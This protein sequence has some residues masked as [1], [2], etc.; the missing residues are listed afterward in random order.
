MQGY[1]S[2]PSELPS[3]INETAIDNRTDRGAQKP[4]A[5]LDSAAASIAR[6]VV[7]QST[8]KIG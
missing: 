7:Q 4:G 1:G 6:Q 8:G 5:I 2:R 3:E